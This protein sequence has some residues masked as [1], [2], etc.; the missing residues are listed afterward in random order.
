MNMDTSSCAHREILSDPGCRL[1]EDLHGL[2]HG[3]DE[4]AC[5]DEHESSRARDHD[6]AIFRTHDDLVEFFLEYA[7]DRQA[8]GHGE[9]TGESR[10]SIRIQMI[11]RH[12]SKSNL[13]SLGRCQ[14]D[15]FYFGVLGYECNFGLEEFDIMFYQANLIAEFKCRLYHQDLAR[16]SPLCFPLS[17]SPLS[18]YSSIQALGEFGTHFLEFLGLQ[19][20]VINRP[21]SDGFIHVI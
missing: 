11:A 7:R 16:L 15:C 8:A 19:M 9:R 2:H 20:S 5:P 10:K 14:R 13:K 17:E 1:A 4:P 6:V 21:P 18:R 3:I 12:S